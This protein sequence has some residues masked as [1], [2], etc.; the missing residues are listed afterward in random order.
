MKFCNGTWYLYIRQK[1]QISQ[2]CETNKPCFTKHIS[3]VRTSTFVHWWVVLKFILIRLFNEQKLQTF[4]L[5]R[6]SD[7]SSL[8]WSFRR[9]NDPIE[10]S[11]MIDGSLNFVLAS[12]WRISWKSLLWETFLKYTVSY[13]FTNQKFDPSLWANQCSDQAKNHR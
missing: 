10:S 2:N 12:T 9:L 8:S 4:L 1:R 11:S 13:L 6:R 7:K 5:L 3:G